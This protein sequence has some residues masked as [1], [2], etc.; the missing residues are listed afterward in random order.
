MTHIKEQVEK[1]LTLYPE[2]RNS[3]IKLLARIWS[4]DYGLDYQKVLVAMASANPATIGRA[5]RKI[6][7]KEL[8]Q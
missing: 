7:E 6:Q 4:T 3:D 8:A 5:K 1:A 2:T